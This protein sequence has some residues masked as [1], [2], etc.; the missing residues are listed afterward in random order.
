MAIQSDNE[1]TQLRID[2]FN[3]S[4]PEDTDPRKPVVT[5]TLRGIVDEAKREQLSDLPPDS[6]M[7]CEI[8]EQPDGM[9]QVVIDESRFIELRCAMMNQQEAKYTRDDLIKKYK[10]ISAIYYGEESQNAI[11]AQQAYRSQEELVRDVLKE[12]E[13]C[14]RKRD[15]FQTSEPAKAERLAAQIQAY[16][17]VLTIMNF[18]RKKYDGTPQTQEGEG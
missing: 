15:F 12:R 13:R 2:R 3:M 7:S 14:I 1:Q 17:R 16:D 4:Y 6:G 10:H 8:E 9:H 11:F 5:L 18:L